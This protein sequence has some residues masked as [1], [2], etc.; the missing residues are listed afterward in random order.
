MGYAE[1]IVVLSSSH[2]LFSL[3]EGT[4]DVEGERFIMRV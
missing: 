4:L 3:F 2:P 1:L